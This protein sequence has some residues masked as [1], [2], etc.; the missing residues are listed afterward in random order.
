ML[1]NYFTLYHA[2]REL[3]ER[4][5]G[6]LLNRVLCRQKNELTLSFIT[7]NGEPLQLL[8]VTGTPLLSFYTK[9]EAEGTSRNAASL[10]AAVHGQRV[11]AV[12]PSLT[13]REIFIRLA[14]RH[15]IVLRLFSPRSNALL[16]RDNHIIEAFKQN[17]A[18][19]GTIRE[20]SSAQPEILKELEMLAR[21]KELFLQRAGQNIPGFDLTLSG[22]LREKAGPQ[23]TGDTLFTT[24]QSIFYDLLDPVPSVTELE[25]GEP[26]FTLL[27]NHEQKGRT[28]DSILEALNAYSISMQRFLGVKEE[29]DSFQALLRRQLDKAEKELLAFDPEQLDLLAARYETFGHLLLSALY[30]PDREPASIKVK[31]IFDP[32]EPPLSIPLKPALSIQLNAREYF[33][34]ASKTR[35]K[36]TAMVER[37]AGLEGKIRSLSAL[38]AESESIT[39]PRVARRFLAEQSKSGETG[40][41]T[42]PGKKQKATPFRTVAISKSVTLLVGKNAAGNDQLTFEHTRPDDIWLHARGAPGS[43]CV[44]KGASLEGITEIRR[45]AEIAAWHSSAKHSSLVPVIYTRKKYVRRSKN[46]APGQVEVERENVILVRPRKE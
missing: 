22:K 18:L 16:L 1:R 45:A 27:Q 23:P 43:H 25:S 10:M 33:S 7:P 9:E 17:D 37:H 5:A 29:L 26:E 35:G 41:T 12:E 3:H 11:S 13:D 39:T 2:A 6:G 28:F 46:R 21:D 36:R 30:Q 34:K 40:K 19:A 31:N 42:G 4:L 32:L 44:L 15:L 38:L 24:F 8:L 14:D 20:P